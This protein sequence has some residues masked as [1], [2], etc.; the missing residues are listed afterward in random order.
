MSEVM[1]VFCVGLFSDSHMTYELARNKSQEP[2]L[3]EM[4]TK[5]IEILKK[6]DKG[7]FLLVEGETASLFCFLFCFSVCV[8]VCVCLRVRARARVCS[9]LGRELCVC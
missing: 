3:S 1:F 4:T 6:N 7:F 8:C 5:A 2:S 9:R